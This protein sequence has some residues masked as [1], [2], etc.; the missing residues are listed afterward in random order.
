VDGAMVYFGSNDSVFYALDK[1]KGQKIWS[2]KTKGAIKSKAA[3]SSA[4][5]IFNDEAGYVNAL[6]KTNG[7]IIWQ[8][9][10]GAEQRLDMWDYYLSSPVVS[11]GIVYI[12]SGDQHVYAINADSGELMW[13]YKTQGIVHAAPLVHKD[14]LFIGSLDGQFYALDKQTGSE[15][16]KFRTIGDQYF[17]IGGIQRSASIYNDKVIFGS[18]DYNI[19]ALDIDKGTGHWNMKE[20]GSWIIA[21]PLVEGDYLYFGTSDTHRFYCM[22][23]VTSEIKW[24]KPL[25]M[26]VYATAIAHR[27]RVYFACFNGKIYGLNKDTG[28]EEFVFQTTESQGNYSSLFK[29]E[30]HFADGIQL[31]G[32]DA[33]EVEQQILKLGA[34][35]TTPCI[36]DG[37]MFFGDANGYFYAIKL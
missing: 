29:S 14:K 22:N 17:P 9:K 28:E 6:D 35:L 15:L 32:E 16:W 7:A 11:D 21:T 18:R 36:D 34:I 2:Y 27:E 31:Y 4:T 12:G 5:I 20:R 10:M 8:F 30:T 24:E 26:R 1:Q 37:T 25:N 19:Y 3:I 33:L 23:A 13:K